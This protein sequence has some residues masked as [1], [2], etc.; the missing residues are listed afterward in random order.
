[1]PDKSGSAACTFSE[2]TWEGDPVSHQKAPAVPVQRV[3]DKL[4]GVRKGTQGYTALCPAHDDNNPSLSVAEGDDGRVLVHCFAGCDVADIVAAIDLEM[5]DL[6]PS[7]TKVQRRGT[8]RHGPH[9]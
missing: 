7:E 4:E 8:K 5:F 1:A 3:L 6:F 2:T 9:P